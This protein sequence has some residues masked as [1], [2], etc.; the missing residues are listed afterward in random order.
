MTGV[1]VPGDASSVCGRKIA[2][3]AEPVKVRETYPGNQSSKG[4]EPRAFVRLG[5]KLLGVELT[6]RQDGNGRLF[7]NHLVFDCPRISGKNPPPKHPEVLLE[8]AN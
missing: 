6:I 1:A 7:P 3:K 8:P 5:N 4:A 2:T